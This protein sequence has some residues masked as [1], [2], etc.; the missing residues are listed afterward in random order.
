MPS[1]LSYLVRPNPECDNTH[2]GTGSNTV[3]ANW[4]AVTGV[5]DWKEFN[6]Q[7]VLSM[8]GTLL[9]HSFTDL[10]EISPP[11]RP[12]ECE[13]WDEDSLEHFLTRS[14]I[15]IVRTSLVKAWEY[16]QSE[17]NS[18][19]FSGRAIDIGRGGR[20]TNPARYNDTRYRPDWAGIRKDKI[21]A[22][23]YRNL[24]PG[25]TKLSTKWKSVWSSDARQESEFL[26]PVSQIQ[27]YC[28]QHHLVRYG[29][30]I[31]QEELYVVQVSSKAILPGLALT[32]SPRINPITRSSHK[33][34]ESITSA[35]S[36]ISLTMSSSYIEDGSNIE[37]NHIKVKSIPWSN[38]GKGK[39]SIKLALWWLHMLAAAPKTDISIHSNYPPLDSWKSEGANYRHNSTGQ[40]AKHLPKR[41]IVDMSGTAGAVSQQQDVKQG[42][43][44]R[45]SVK[46]TEIERPTTASTR[47]KTWSATRGQYFWIDSMNRTRWLTT[48]TLV[49]D[50]GYRRHY[51]YE[52]RQ[53]VWEA[54]SDSDEDETEDE[55]A[56]DMDIDNGKG[57]A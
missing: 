7:T 39:L 24:C 31:T 21:T 6:Y 51:R 45:G 47:K 38:S 34:D 57:K 41:G 27:S 2:S 4:A 29:Y 15:P 19:D 23:G 35:I 42:E 17:W 55:E 53:V 36:Q 14:I 12:E 3:N 8:Y 40:L 11:L 10:P 33:R 32:R 52:G 1:L 26:P 44:S 9:E 50:E 37:F 20:A 13:I 54:K 48:D 46:Q 30:L 49:W 28:G 16:C 56:S 5:E 43:P 25:D 22:T 18:D